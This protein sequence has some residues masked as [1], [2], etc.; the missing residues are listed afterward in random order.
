MQPTASPTLDDFVDMQDLLPSVE[1]TFPTKDSLGWFIR[2]HRDTLVEAGAL[3]VITGRLRFHPQRF[4]EVAV[5][6]GRQL[7]M[8]RAA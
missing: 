3:I 6:I 7:A 8:V 5:E 4:K 2:R 1:Q